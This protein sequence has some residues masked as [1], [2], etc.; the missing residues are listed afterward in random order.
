V[1]EHLLVEERGLAPV[2]LGQTPAEFGGATHASMVSNVRSLCIC[3]RWLCIIYLS[4][5]PY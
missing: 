3:V 2:V 4:G 1:D 5:G